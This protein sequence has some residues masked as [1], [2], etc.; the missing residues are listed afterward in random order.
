MM[1]SR[2]TLLALAPALLIAA[3]PAAVRAQDAPSVPT[4]RSVYFDVGALARDRIRGGLEALAVGRFTVGLAGSYSH[5]VDQ[6]G[7]TYLYGTRQVDVNGVYCAYP[8]SFSCVGPMANPSRYRAWAL[9]LSVRWYPSFLSFQNGP[10]RMMAYVGEFVGYHWRT[11]DEQVWYYGYGVDDVVPVMASRDTVI[12]PA[13]DT[14]PWYPSY[15]IAPGPNPIRHTLN[16]IQPGAEVGVR[17]VPFR[18]L[19]I[20]VGARFMLVTI[21]DPLQR[22]LKGDVESRLVVA[23]GLAF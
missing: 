16:A 21:D 17:L 22:T 2:R 11:W 10:S 18:R 15:P 6:D 5:T 20:D 8:E 1:V 3:V 23:G 7:Y 19:L 9:D 14:L 13:S 4:V 12:P